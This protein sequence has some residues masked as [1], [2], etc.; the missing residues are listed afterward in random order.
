LKK[1]TIIVAKGHKVYQFDDFLTKTYTPIIYTIDES[2][3]KKRIE[4]SI[5]E[6]LCDKKLLILGMV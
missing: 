1:I 6:E 5:V 2:L 3:V 4:E